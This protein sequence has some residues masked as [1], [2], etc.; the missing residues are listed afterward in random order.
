MLT[1]HGTM[2]GFLTGCPGRLSRPGC[3]LMVWDV[4]TDPTDPKLLG[5]FECP[6]GQ[7]VH[8]SFYNGGRYAISPVVI[9]DMR[10]LF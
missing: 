9:M 3:G 7:G 8:R 6:G 10:V 5:T 1:A 2:A 4:K